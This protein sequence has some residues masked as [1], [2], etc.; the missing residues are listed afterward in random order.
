MWKYISSFKKFSL[1]TLRD[2]CLKIP[3]PYLATPTTFMAIVVSTLPF[4]VTPYAMKGLVYIDISF[5]TLR[6]PI[7]KPLFRPLPP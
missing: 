4:L 2:S 5:T 6:V 1:K 3:K 7:V